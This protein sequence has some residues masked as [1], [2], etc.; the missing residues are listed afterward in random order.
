MPGG[1]R[2]WTIR[3][4]SATLNVTRE[5]TF[6]GSKPSPIISAASPLS[7]MH[8]ERIA[9][10]GAADHQ[11]VD[12]D[13]ADQAGSRHAREH[14]DLARRQPQL[15]LRVREQHE[16]IAAAVGHQA[17]RARIAVVLMRG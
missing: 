16:G 5:N 15:A 14:A 9:Q 4:R 13:A 7:M 10:T 3:Y 12:L 17:E 6:S 8:G 2:V 11:A 1:Y